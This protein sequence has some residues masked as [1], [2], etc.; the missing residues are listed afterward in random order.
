MKSAH[1]MFFKGMLVNLKSSTGSSITINCYQEQVFNCSGKINSISSTCKSAQKTYF[2]DIELC[3]QDVIENTLIMWQAHDRSYSNN[4]IDG[5]CCAL[6]SVERCLDVLKV[7]NL[8]KVNKRK[9]V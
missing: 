1:D 4:M 8:F 2:S 6:K 7:F 9:R 3:K 5:G